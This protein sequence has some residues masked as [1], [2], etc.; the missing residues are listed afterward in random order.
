[1]PGL[2]RLPAEARA[3]TEALRATPAG[4]HAL[5]MFREE[6]RRVLIKSRVA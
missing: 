5:R 2:E 4:A 1:M 6:R 3:L